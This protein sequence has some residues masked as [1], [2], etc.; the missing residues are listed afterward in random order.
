MSS[1]FGFL[2][3]LEFPQTLLSALIASLNPAIIHNIE[4]Y[5]ILKK[6]HYL[7]AIE[8]LRGDYLEFGVFTGSS[9]AHSIRCYKKMKYLSEKLDNMNFYGFDSFDGFGE[10]NDSDK[11]PFYTDN[12]FKTSI[13]TVNKRISKAAGQLK[14]RLV[15]GFFS[16][17]LQLGPSKYGIEKASI[18]FVDSDTYSSSLDALMFCKELIQPG[19]YI[20]LDDF[21]SYRGNSQKGVKRAF[22]EL[23]LITGMDLR[24]VFTYGMGGA[25]FVVDKL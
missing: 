25:V 7:C 21:Y 4:K 13:N 19:T 16:D 18:I 17:S 2:H 23:I 1:K 24:R 5:Y 6:V 22:D 3:K 9:F 12:N 14:Y 15:S 8:D 11:H 20:I 10:L